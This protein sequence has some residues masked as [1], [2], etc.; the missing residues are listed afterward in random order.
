MWHIFPQALLYFEKHDL[1]Q[2]FLN[3]ALEWFIT[4]LTKQWCKA[5][6]MGTVSLKKRDPRRLPRY[7]SL[8]SISELAISLVNL[9]ELPCQSP[10][11]K[12]M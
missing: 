1:L 7:P 6:K 9:P 4:F 5:L 2:S 10:L 3:V 12:H 11:A 8:I